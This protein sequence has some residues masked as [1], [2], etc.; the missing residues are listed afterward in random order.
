MT[1]L[2]RRCSEQVLLQRLGWS[3]VEPSCLVGSSMTVPTDLRLVT[4]TRCFG[5]TAFRLAMPTQPRFGCSQLASLPVTGLAAVAARFRQ[6]HWLPLRCCPGPLDCSRLSASREWLDCSDA[7]SSAA[8]AIVIA[9]VDI[10]F[11]CY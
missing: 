3:I 9:F 5:C 10:G 1:G 8:S 4:G 6:Y 2:A 7:A 11:A